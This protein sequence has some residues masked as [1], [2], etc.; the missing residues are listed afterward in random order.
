[1][2]SFNNPYN[3]LN[4]YII[5]ANPEIIMMGIE[6]IVVSFNKNEVTNYSQFIEKLN[7]I[8]KD[9]GIIENIF[10]K[11]GFRIV[12]FNNLKINNIW[13]YI[14]NNDIIQATLKY[15]KEDNI[16]NKCE[17][18]IKETN[19]ENII[20][21][22]FS[23][24]NSNYITSKSNY[25]K[26]I[27]LKYKKDNN[28]LNN[29]DLNKKNK[30][31]YSY[32]LEE[33][34][35]SSS[36]SYSS[37][38]EVNNK[39]SEIQDKKTI[40]KPMKAKDK[41]NKNIDNES[42]N[43][44]NKKFLGKKRISKNNNIKINNFVN[45][46]KQNEKISKINYELIPSDKLDDIS[47]LNS[48]YPK[49]FLPGTKVKFKIQELLKTGIGVGDYHF[50]VIDNFNSQNNS[51]L[52]KD[53]SSLNEKTMLFM[54]QYDDDLMCIELKNFV[55]IWIQTEKNGKD[56][57]EKDPELIK[58]F[59]RRQTEFYF[60]DKN[61]E[62][63]SFLKQNEDEKGYIPINIIM[64]FNKIKM[65]TKDRN[66]FIEALKE[67][68]N[69]NLGEDNNKSYELNEDFTKIRKKIIN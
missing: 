49:L 15:H 6:K 45:K 11:E 13:N 61:Y 30:K 50:G 66:E 33:S 34:S 55:E 5:N 43:T 8:F 42:E 27:N 2:S 58:H 68:G 64:N 22:N 10:N 41:Y 56:Y 51:F 28:N 67:E 48:N 60:C 63:D 16:K 20:K 40:E 47:F 14:T 12:E 32:S 38:K 3:K 19:N 54:Y 44:N 29:I 23:N 57:L 18:Y 31:N 65:I 53:C 9:Y 36:S 17:K 39:Y 21:K 69:K 37:E 7:D 26:N 1:M 25:P 46:A 62:K 59:I 52:I 35:E 24:S 4:I